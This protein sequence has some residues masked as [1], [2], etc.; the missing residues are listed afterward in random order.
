ISQD[1]VEPMTREL[2]TLLSVA[3]LLSATAILRA[4][5]WPEW[6]GPARTG[7]S[8]ETSLPSSWSPKGE[9][10]AW[11][12]PYGGRSSPVAFRDRLYFLTTTPGD[13]ATTQERLVALDA[14]SGKML[15]QRPFSIYL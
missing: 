1:S 12:V 3:L 10:L 4:A 8:A 7:V 14:E 6:R 15:W 11:R 9:N 13:L 2:R 5:D